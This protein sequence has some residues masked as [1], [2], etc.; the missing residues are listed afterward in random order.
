M[1]GRI[2]SNQF[3]VH[4]FAE[5]LWHPNLQKKFID[6]GGFI[7]VNHERPGLDTYVELLNPKLA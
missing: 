6:K 3:P 1:P 5:D 2:P 7:I 4:S